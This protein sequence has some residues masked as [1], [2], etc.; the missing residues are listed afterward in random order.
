MDEYL[1]SKNTD[2]GCIL[3]EGFCK[4]NPDKEHTIQKVNRNTKPICVN[5]Q[6]LLPKKT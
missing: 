4:P 5:F 3:D 1:K 6:A 2:S